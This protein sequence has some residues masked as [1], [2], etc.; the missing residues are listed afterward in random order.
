MERIADEVKERWD[1][2]CAIW[3]RLGTLTVGE[4]SV[5]VAVASPHRGVAF[6]ACRFAIDRVKETVPVWKKEIAED[7]YWW[8]EDPLASVPAVADTS[9]ET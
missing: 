1:V 6:E 9:I 7:G 5:V 3:H 2:P 8:V 4:A